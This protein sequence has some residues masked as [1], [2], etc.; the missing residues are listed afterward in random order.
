MFQFGAPVSP[1]VGAP[2]VNPLF[3][4]F[5][6]AVSEPGPRPVDVPM[7]PHIGQPRPIDPGAPSPLLLELISR[8][9]SP[10]EAISQAG[11]EL[12]NRIYEGL[13]P[14]PEG[15]GGVGHLL[16]L[17]SHPAVQRLFARRGVTPTFDPGVSLG[18]GHGRPYMGRS[19]STIAATRRREHGERNYQ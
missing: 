13:P 5:G 12:G 16:E 14:Q 4:L 1:G 17:L 11:H 3:R 9:L 19:Q 10:I 2:P 15:D 8:R 7:P 6:G 18:R